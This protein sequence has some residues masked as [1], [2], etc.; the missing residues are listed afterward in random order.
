ML[1]HYLVLLSSISFL[2]I[3]SK[4]YLSCVTRLRCELSLTFI[5]GNKA[6]VVIVVVVVVGFPGCLN[7]E[8][9]NEKRERP[10][11]R[12]SVSVS[13]SKEGRMFL[14][15]LDLSPHR[16]GSLIFDLVLK[17]GTNVAEDDTISFLQSSIVDGKLGELSVNVSYIFGIPPIEQST[18]AV[19]SPSTTPKSDGLF[20][21]LVDSGSI[22]LS[23]LQLLL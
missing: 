5:F 19:A 1:K 2:V 16:C 14:F 10:L 11:K 21:I 13:F 15:R 4:C 23:A 9:T 7:D 12:Q 18:T 8:R 17:F 22:N 20:Q 3:L 6:G